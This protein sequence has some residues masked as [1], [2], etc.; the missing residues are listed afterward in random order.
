MSPIEKLRKEAQAAVTE[1]MVAADIAKEQNNPVEL[2]YVRTRQ[3]VNLIQRLSYQ[4]P[5]P[6]K[7]VPNS[8]DSQ[9][10]PKCSHPMMQGPLT[11][12]KP[13]SRDRWTAAWW[14]ANCH[15]S[16]EQKEEKCC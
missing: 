15:F 6:S 13:N 12:R 14:C 4:I 11:V 8:T 1:L 2:S 5:N 7:P 10:C 3:L 9:S 16:I